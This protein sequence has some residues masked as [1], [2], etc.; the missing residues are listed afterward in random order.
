VRT[1]V[2][3]EEA[4]DLFSQYPF[5]LVILETDMP[6][7]DGYE[8]CVQIRTISDVPIL[9]LSSSTHI[10]DLVMAFN[11]GAD[12]FMLKPFDVK[13]L[14]ARIHA[15]L[16]RCM[17]NRAYE[18]RQ[19]IRYGP[20]EL[21]PSTHEVYV[22]GKETALTASEYRLLKHLMQKPDQPIGK[23]EILKEVWGYTVHDDTSFVR[24]T[25]SRLRGKIEANPNQPQ[26]L[27]TVHGFGYQFCTVPTE[28]KAT[29]S[30]STV[31]KST[32]KKSTVAKPEKVDG[33]HRVRYTKSAKRTQPAKAKSM[34]LSANGEHRSYQGEGAMAF[35]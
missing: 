8:A 1:A 17:G 15:T 11:L 9:M 30:K 14:L 13:V 19:V 6:H 26:Y 2:D 20:I 21:N 22:H 5:E 33:R 31:S 16:R 10:D 7:M 24:V 4:F 35:A 25:M 18:T 29:V 12:N 32:V 23:A 27:Q 28:T 3:G 34:P